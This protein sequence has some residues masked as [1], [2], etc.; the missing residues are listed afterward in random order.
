MS[1]LKTWSAVRIILARYYMLYMHYMIML[2]Y[3]QYVFMLYYL[4]S[5]QLV[6]LRPST[7]KTNNTA[8]A[9]AH[10]D[11]PP[12]QIIA[13][14]CIGALTVH[15]PAMQPP[16]GPH[17]NPQPPPQHTMTTGQ[18]PPQPYTQQPFT[19]PPATQ[20]PPLP[21]GHPHS[22]P[23]A[24]WLP[25]YVATTGPEYGYQPLA[26]TSYTW[27]TTHPPTGGTMITSWG[28]Y[29]LAPQAA[30]Q[31]GPQL[32]QLLHH[33]AQQGPHQHQALPHTQP[34]QLRAPTHP[35][36][37]PQLSA[38]PTPPT[39]PL[40]Y[41]FPP[42]TQHGPQQPPPL[43][44]PHNSLPRLRHCSLRP[45]IRPSNGPMAHRLRQPR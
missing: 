26:A 19:N 41:T 34:Q 5:M 31:I 17:S 42:Q 6:A 9:T 21:G 43:S 8:A 35:H 4:P 24:P 30:I 18:P 3:D 32:Q 22:T 40:G 13:W 44:R 45:A 28:G 29:S 39:Q 7:L 16:R 23:Q 37:I 36:H 15:T 11:M 38:Q 27:Q 14:M 1:L 2:S 20:A 25:P 33:G 10:G 12:P